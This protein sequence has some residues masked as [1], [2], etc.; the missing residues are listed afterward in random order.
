MEFTSEMLDQ[1]K[2]NVPSEELAESNLISGNV[3]HLEIP[4][5]V[6][7]VYFGSLAFIKFFNN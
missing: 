5:F 1:S 2:E 6:L 4:E 3:F 7:K